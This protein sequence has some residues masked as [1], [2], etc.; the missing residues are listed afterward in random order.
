[1]RE[2]RRPGAPIARDAAREADGQGAD[3]NRGEGRDGQVDVNAG[4]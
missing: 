2:N 1:M 4:Q 3:Q